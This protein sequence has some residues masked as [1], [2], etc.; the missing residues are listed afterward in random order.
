MNRALN[1]LDTVRQQLLDTVTP[2]DSATFSRRPSETEWSVA[3]IVEHLSLVEDRV[4]S[5]LAKAVER[6]PQHLP[7]LRRLI[8]TSVVALRLV[9]V[10][11]P[12]AV[13]PTE[14]KTKE[15]GLEQLSRS[16]AQLKALCDQHGEQRLRTVVFKH[17]FLGPIGGV[18]A[19]SFV[20]YHERRHLKQIREVLRKIN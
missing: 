12:R 14:T 4:R 7:L 11:S 17:P 9:R 3:D 18:A 10:K 8:P 19:V 16:R 13:T 20:G 2:L 15:A 5:D 1:R 6:E